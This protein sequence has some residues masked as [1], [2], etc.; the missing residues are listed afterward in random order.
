MFPHFCLQL[1]A[2]LGPQLDFSKV[3]KALFPDGLHP[4]DVV[5]FYGDEGSG[6]TQML[7]HLMTKCLLPAKWNDVELGG[8]NAGVV[9]VDTDYQFSVE[10]LG[11]VLME[12]VASCLSWARKMS[13]ESAR[14][15]MEPSPEDLDSLLR[16]SLDK[17][18]IVKCNSSVQFVA[19]LY[20]LESVF[21]NHKDVVSF[22]FV[23]SI[24]AFYWID[25]SNGADNVS[26]QELNQRRVCDAL[27]KLRS[28]SSF[29]TVV[30]KPAL[31]Q[32]KQGKRFAPKEHA[33]PTSVSST[34][35]TSTDGCSDHC[36]YLCKPWQKLVSHRYVFTKQDVVSE[37]D[38]KVRVNR[39]FT[40]KGGRTSCNS[41]VVSNFY[42]TD[43]GVLFH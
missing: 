18:Q 36:E 38:G 43:M 41:P 10:R 33:S 24:S 8:L 30:T 12:R 23:D 7:I 35:A 20:R 31:F 27:Q 5:E 37:K 9:L 32:K 1:L 13:L 15:F 25:R 4:K 28:N 17:L 34:S 21:V 26:A 3:E 11:T 19:S 29:V 14:T 22:L 2:R 6:K 16:K 39:L 40:V 42:V